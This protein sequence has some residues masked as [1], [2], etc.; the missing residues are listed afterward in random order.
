MAQAILR[1]HGIKAA[2]ARAMGCDWTT[3]DD[4]CN[5][6]PTCTAA[7]KVARN[8][9]VDAAESS[10]LQ[11]MQAGDNWAIGKILDNL[12]RDRGWG[13]AKGDSTD[14]ITITITHS[15]EVT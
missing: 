9:V 10:L 11:K 3:V 14:P 13:T 8:E 2:A 6:Y 7:L 5:K 15:E 12:G 1:A 4:Y